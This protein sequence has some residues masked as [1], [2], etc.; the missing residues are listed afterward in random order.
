MGHPEADAD[1]EETSR[2]PCATSAHGAPE[3][4]R[5][6]KNPKREYGAWGTR[7]LRRLQEP[8]A[9]RR[10]MGHPEADADADAD[11]EETSRTPS[12]TAAHGAPEGGRRVK[13]PKR[14]YGA[15]GTQRQ[16]ARH[17]TPSIYLRHWC[18]CYWALNSGLIVEMAAPGPIC[19]ACY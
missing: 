7:R 3:G 17:R 4:G 13:N 18:D 11:A 16:E 19:L 10:R 1:A 14:R 9:R 5:R 6:V 8:R 12:A 2:T 15:W